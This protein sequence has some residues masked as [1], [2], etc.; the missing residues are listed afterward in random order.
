MAVTP[1][2]TL[3]QAPGAV[4]AILDHLDVVIGLEDKHVSGPDPFEHHPV[5]MAEIS[6]ETDVCR[7]GAQEETDGLLGIVGHTESFDQDIAYFEA[8]TGGEHAPLAGEA[9]LIL[10]RLL[11]G[12]VAINGNVELGGQSDQALHMV[13][14]F[15]G[16]EDRAEVLR[17]AANRGQPFADLT[18]AEPGIDQDAGVISLDIGAV[19]GGAA[20]ENRQANRHGQP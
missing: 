14:M 19:S 6:Q 2:D 4:G 10:D 17:G 20:A 7:G 1:E 16:D 9:Q 11:G 3:F 13:G 8:G 12:T 15:V 5:D 18:E